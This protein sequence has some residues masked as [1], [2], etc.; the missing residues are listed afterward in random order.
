MEIHSLPAAHILTN[1]TDSAS[2]MPRKKTVAIITLFYLS[3]FIVSAEDETQCKVLVDGEDTSREFGRLVAEKGVRIVYLYLKFSNDSYHPLGSKNRI[4]PYRWAWTQS[5]S[6]PLLS[7]SYDY[8][9]LSLGLLN[10]QA[11]S[12]DVNLR[13]SPSGCLAGL[14][15]SRQDI[16]ITRALMDI[17]SLDSSIAPNERTDVVC[18]R[19][20]QEHAFGFGS[21]FKYQCCGEYESDNKSMI[22]CG[23]DIKESEWLKVFNAL[24]A[25]LVTIACLY[26]PLIF[27]ALPTYFFMAGNSM[28]YKPNN[29][30]QDQKLIRLRE[31][32]GSITNQKNNLVN[33]PVDDLSPITFK[34][35]FQILEEKVPSVTYISSIKFFLLWFGFVPIFFYIKLGLYFILKN[36]YFDATSRKLI[37]QVGDFYLF[38]FSMDKP[39]VYVIFLLPMVIIPVQ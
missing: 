25:A 5:R 9:V 18:T 39:L 16:A 10:K 27:C 15:A 34:I 4:L 3:F 11:R 31:D 24:L 21:G 22:N 6:E 38:V 36:N 30:P 33:I 32:D 19:I 2:K 8:D 13:E 1:S 28:D 7:L 20:L 35:I 12:L 26:W 37:F 17:T 29:L 14:N 23:L